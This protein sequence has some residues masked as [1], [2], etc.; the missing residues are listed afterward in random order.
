MGPGSHQPA[1]LI[2]QR[3]EFDLQAT[4]PG[5][6]ALPENFQDQARAVDDL[7]RPA[8]F[9]IALLHRRQVVVHY[10]QFD[11]L[12]LNPALHLFDLAAT[13]QGA[14]L[15]RRQ[16]YDL[17]IGNFKVDGLG[18][19]DGF[20]QACVSGTTLNVAVAQQRMKHQGTAARLRAVVARSVMR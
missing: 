14:W 4:F 19:A 18:K 1:A 6:G 5:L 3:R 16:R 9:Q 17:G 12:G 20:G 7:A 13:E 10:H 2:A 15:G 8:A 11:I